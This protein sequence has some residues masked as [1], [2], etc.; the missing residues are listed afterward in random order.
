ML[1]GTKVFDI[2][3]VISGD[4]QMCFGCLDLLFHS[5]NI[6]VVV[7]RDRHALA[8]PNSQLSDGKLGSS[9]HLEVH[10]WPSVW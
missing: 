4:D 7:C 3:V 5:F 6:L 1:F 8:Q 10:T 2:L 9:R